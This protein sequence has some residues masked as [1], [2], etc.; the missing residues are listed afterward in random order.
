M[1]K[2]NK[3]ENAFLL[4]GIA[5]EIQEV[6]EHVSRFK[7]GPNNITDGECDILLSLIVKIQKSFEFEEPNE[8]F[9]WLKQRI[10]T[11]PKLRPKSFN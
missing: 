4:D 9:E 11:I 10:D 8:H 7:E 5:R 2:L 6:G 1:E 3:W